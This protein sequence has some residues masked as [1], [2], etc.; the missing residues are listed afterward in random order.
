MIYT[1]ETV[2]K[3]SFATICSKIFDN[4]SCELMVN[5]DALDFWAVYSKWTAILF[6]VQSRR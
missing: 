1:V 4:P 3:V 5:T 6:P 2:K